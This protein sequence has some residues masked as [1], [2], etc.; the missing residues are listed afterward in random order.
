MEEKYRI[1]IDSANRNR[2]INPD[3]CNLVINDSDYKSEVNMSCKSLPFQIIR[4]KGDISVTSTGDITLDTNN[5][6]ITLDEFNYKNVF[7]GLPFT[8]LH[9]MGYANGII[10]YIHNVQYQVTQIYFTFTGGFPLPDYFINNIEMLIFFKYEQG[11]SGLTVGGTVN[12][13]IL[14]ATASTVDDY[15]KDWYI[16]IPLNESYV[17]AQVVS[18]NATT[19]TVFLNKNIA[20]PYY[21]DRYYEIS[22]SMYETYS[23]IISNAVKEKNGYFDVR[24]LSLI[25]PHVGIKI[26]NGGT[27]NNYGELYVHL[28]NN[29]TANTSNAI[30]KNNDANGMFIIP[31]SDTNPLAGLQYY[32]LNS[33]FMVIRMYLDFTQP[34]YFTVRLPNNN[35]LILED[36]PPPI[37]PNPLKQIIAIFQLSRIENNDKIDRYLMLS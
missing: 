34:I 5:P 20:L 36:N 21:Q 32:C 29:I 26:F 31:I 7:V 27:L 24:L 37:P 22:N 3:Q 28:G 15:Y 11:E 35:Y 23:P 2:N 13:I 25:I 12:Q 30:I 8:I 4:V 14:S 17:Y 10:T 9:S 19:K 1:Y 33:C 6:F 16:W 18:Y